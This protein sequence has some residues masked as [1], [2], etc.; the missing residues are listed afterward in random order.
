MTGIEAL[1]FSSKTVLPPARLSVFDVVAVAPT[2]YV[3]TA[4]ESH[5]GRMMVVGGG[6][7]AVRAGTDTS[8]D[9]AGVLLSS[10]LLFKSFHAMSQ[11]RNTCGNA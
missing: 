5:S 6:S 4:L 10:F 2:L 7:G 1:N 11:T 9:I 3:C 8:V